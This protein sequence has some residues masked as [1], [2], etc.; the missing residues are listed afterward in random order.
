MVIDHSAKSAGTLDCEQENQIVADLKK[1]KH[2][3][4]KVFLQQRKEKVEGM[5]IGVEKSKK[6]MGINAQDV[7]H[8]RISMH[9]TSFLG[10]IMK[11]LGLTFLT[12]K[13]YVVDAI[14]Y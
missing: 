9:I 2:L 7:D 4:T 10:M 14:A 8:T 11:I 5:T 12:G 13:L 6:E 1:I 3:G